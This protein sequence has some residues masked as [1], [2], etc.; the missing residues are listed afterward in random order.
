MY[1]ENVSKDFGLFTTQVVQHIFEI[2]RPVLYSE[3]KHVSVV[4]KLPD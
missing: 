1:N 4:P 3:N 2:S